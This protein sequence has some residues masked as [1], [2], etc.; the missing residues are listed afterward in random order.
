MINEM[1]LAYP[2]STDIL[3]EQ[4]LVLQFSPINYQVIS[5]KHYRRVEMD[6]W[7]KATL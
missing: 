2:P 3:I 4:W 6:R 7:F 1:A 5:D